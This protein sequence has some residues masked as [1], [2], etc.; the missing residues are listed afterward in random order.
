VKSAA[1][2]VIGVALA[3]CALNLP[4]APSVRPAVGIYAAE[5]CVAVSSA[6]ASCG[7]AQADLRRDGSL[8]VRVDDLVYHLTLHSSQVQV[9][10]MHN[11][12]VIDEFTVPYE[13]M[14]SALEF[15]DTERNSRYEVRL[16]AGGSAKH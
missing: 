3:V 8:N 10:L 14:G 2:Q 9:V 16:H 11:A 13:W 4:A 6:A 15:N 5:L 7:P 12:V 1:L